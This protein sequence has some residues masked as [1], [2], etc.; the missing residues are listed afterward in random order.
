[1]SMIVRALLIVAASIT[2]LF[3]SRDALNFGIIE[4]FVA[5]ILVAAFFLLVAFWKLRPPGGRRGVG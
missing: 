3:V 2:A 4:T 5:V 1:M